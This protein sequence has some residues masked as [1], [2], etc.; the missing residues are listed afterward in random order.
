MSQNRYRPKPKDMEHSYVTNTLMSYG[1]GWSAFELKCNDCA[2]R[3][4][5]T[6]Q[7]QILCCFYKTF[8]A[9]CTCRAETQTLN[10]VKS[11]MKLDGSVTKKVVSLYVCD[12]PWISYSFA[13]N[14]RS[15]DFSF[16]DDG[17]IDVN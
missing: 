11:N 2:R 13:L 6:L 4:M 8:A 17:I 5:Y 14:T 12:F 15:L 10:Q 7:H 16:T 3:L 9:V 1:F